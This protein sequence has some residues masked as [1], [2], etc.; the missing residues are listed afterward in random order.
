MVV[1][2]DLLSCVKS[3]EIY[4]KCNFY[5]NDYGNTNLNINYVENVQLL[6]KKSAI[7]INCFDW[8]ENIPNELYRIHAWKN[9]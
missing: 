3:A 6:W 2:P 5:F 1:D 9:Q 4:F 8:N 7:D